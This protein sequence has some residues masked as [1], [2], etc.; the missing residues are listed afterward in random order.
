[1]KDAIQ[2]LLELQKLDSA[3]ADAKRELDSIPKDIMRVETKKSEILGILEGRKR[4]LEEL[5]KRRE[6]M[7][8]TRKALEEKAQKYKVLLASMKKQADYDAAN[9]EIEKFLKQAGSIEEE[10]LNAMF[11]IDS[12]KE[13][14]KNEESMTSAS[15]KNLEC[16]IE[17]IAAKK[18]PLEEAY[19][20]AKSALEAHSVPENYLEVYSNLKNSGKKFPIVVKWN[21]GCCGGCHI[22]VSATEREIESSDNPVCCEHCGRILY[23]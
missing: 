16:E 8:S 21:G 4:E 23:V 22:K 20:N 10:E 11:E 14:L 5:E 9:A 15:V 3:L 13:A 12:R 2:K 19:A 17:S 7:R 6:E 1:M 18:V